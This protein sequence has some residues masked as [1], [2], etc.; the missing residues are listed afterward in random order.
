MPLRTIKQTIVFRRPFRLPGVEQVLDAGAYRCEMDEETIDGLSFTAYRR[1]GEYIFLH[2][3]S[4]S[5]GGGRMILL[6]PGAIAGAVETAG[7]VEAL[8][9]SMERSQPDA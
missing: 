6:Q 9:D 3:T 1:V 8:G 7:V 4:G 2:R 5:P